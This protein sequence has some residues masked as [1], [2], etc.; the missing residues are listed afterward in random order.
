MNVLASARLGSG[1]GHGKQ[2][3]NSPCRDFYS[4]SKP[5]RRTGAD[6]ECGRQQDINTLLTAQLSH[7]IKTKNVA[8]WLLLAP[9][10]LLLITV[11]PAV[12]TEAKQWRDPLLTVFVQNLLGT[13]IGH[14]FTAA[15]LFYGLNVNYK[16]IKELLQR[17]N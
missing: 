13:V 6:L 9:T 10:I 5:G 15:P 7:L 8:Q 3:N 12:I 14:S 17:Y 4:K 2:E 16:I 11:R 1:S